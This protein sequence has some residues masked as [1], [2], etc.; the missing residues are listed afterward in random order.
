MISLH[1]KSKYHCLLLSTSITVHRGQILSGHTAFLCSSHSL[2]WQ[3]ETG[4]GNSG[5]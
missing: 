1:K 5:A 2:T 3:M 4:E